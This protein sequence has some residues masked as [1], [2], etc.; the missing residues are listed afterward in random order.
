[1]R[2]KLLIGTALLATGIAVASCEKTPSG[3]PGAETQNQ[4]G[5]ERSE[6]VTQGQQPAGQK[7][8]TQQSEAPKPPDQGTQ[9][10]E[11]QKPPDRGTQQQLSEGEGQPTG[12]SAQDRGTSQRGATRLRAIVTLCNTSRGSP[13]SLSRV[14]SSR[15]SLNKVKF[16]R[17]GLNRT[18][19]GRTSRTEAAPPSAQ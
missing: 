8:G 3:E 1:M 7:Q 19:L 6:D 4:R 9:Q 2:N 11:A 18:S 14:K 13:T 16:S 17:A 5:S 15:A 12:G 10:S